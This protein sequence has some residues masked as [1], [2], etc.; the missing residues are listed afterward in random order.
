MK[1]G[2]DGKAE[3]VSFNEELFSLDR[4]D[5]TAE[6]LDRR[7]EMAIAIAADLICGTFKCG[8]HGTCA[9]FSCGTYNVV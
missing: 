5:L 3:I 8:R 9:D 7:L 4:G 2:E 1:K 6:A